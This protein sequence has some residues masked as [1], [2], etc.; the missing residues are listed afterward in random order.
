MDANAQYELYLI[1][2]ELQSVIN[3]LYTVADGVNRDFEGIGN[4]R[5]SASIKKIAQQCEQAKNKLDNMNLSVVTE[6]FAA[7]QR[8][9]AEAK[10]RAQAQAK[11]RAEAEARAKAEAKARAEAEARAKAEAK[12]R[13]EAEA[14]AKAEAKA[15]AEAEAKKKK[16]DKESNNIWED[17]FGWLFK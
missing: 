15:K 5:C 12:A 8:A 13:A 14:R 2:N 6:E 1:K 16:Q 11:A 17:M 4:E 10:A 3:E 7:K 9:E